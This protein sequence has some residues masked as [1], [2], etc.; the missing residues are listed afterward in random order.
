M[1]RD[2]EVVVGVE[3]VPEAVRACSTLDRIDY[4]D[5]VTV[6]TEE[7]DA[8]PEEWIRAVLEQTPIGRS[9]PRL[10]HA[11]GL[12][13]GPRPSPDHVQGWAIADRGADSIRVETTSWMM[14]GEAVVQVGGGN[15]S[16]ALFLRYDSAVAPWIWRVVSIQHRRAVPVMLH[17]AITVLRSRAAHR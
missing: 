9:A 1:T 11:L 14:S 16:L 12:R 10:W 17:E 3:N 4:A 15:V 2:I 8:T 13:L 6:A 7:I 5:A